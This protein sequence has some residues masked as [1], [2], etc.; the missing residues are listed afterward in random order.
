M[1]T[2][3]STLLRAAT[4]IA[5]VT[6]CA[7]LVGLLRIFVLT[8]TVGDDLTVADAYLAA[9]TVPNIVFE[10]VAGGALAALVVPVL[11]APLER[12]DRA[13]VDR[14]V[15]GLLTWAVVLLAPLAVVGALLR[16][17]VMRL[18]TDDPA[19]VAIG[20]R[21]LLVFMPQVVLYG[22]GI[23]LTGVLQAHHR[24]VGPALAPLLS[25]ALVIGAYLLYDSYRDV[26]L[27]SREEAALAVGTTLGVVLLSLSLMVPAARLRLRLRPT[28]SLPPGVGAQVR[29]LAGYAAIGVAAQQ[30]LLG[31]VLRLADPVRG[32]VLTYNVAYTAFLLP[33]GI[34]A[35]PIATSAFPSLARSAAA[36]DE[37]GYADTAAHALRAVVG[38]AMLAAAAM[39]AVAEPAARLLLG[40]RS[41][42]G[43]PDQLAS[44]LRAFAPGLVGYAV[45]ALGMRAHYARDDGRSPAVAGAVGFAVAA[46]A[47]LLGS[48][49]FH[50][51]HRIVVLAAGHSV[52]M[53]VTGGL[54]VRSLGRTSPGA[55]AGAARSGVVGVAAALVAAAAGAAV[56]GALPEAGTLGEMGRT[57]AAAAVAVTAFLAVAA[58]GGALPRLTWRTAGPGGDSG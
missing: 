51:D 23:V 43:D 8:R 26:G 27:S 50:V 49:W 15:S 3:R 46:I 48:V 54:L 36:G 12:A 4:A 10:L 47:D 5:L 22:V 33:W 57:A 13:E 39:V 53:A 58:W 32:G 55:T 2:A 41:D 17:P 29:R 37:K 11:A 20:S 1:S 19:K 16:E 35:V 31:L 25:S 18:V 34:L 44:V 45:L 9:N 6:V 24:F 21:M 7:R 40:V 14:T 28:L 42:T 52:G 56:C 38:T 30:L